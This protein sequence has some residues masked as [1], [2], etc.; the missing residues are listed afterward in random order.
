MNQE[1]IDNETEDD[2]TSER[3]ISFEIPIITT[4]SPSS[5]HDSDEISSPVFVNIL[6]RSATIVQS[7][8]ETD[9]SFSTIV[10]NNTQSS[11]AFRS[12]SPGNLNSSNT[13][14]GVMSHKISFR[15]LWPENWIDDFKLFT[16]NVRR[17][18]QSLTSASKGR[19]PKRAINILPSRLQKCK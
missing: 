17:W 12:L 13:S 18:S 16:Q 3:N 4:S 2:A 9:T 7:D 5:V 10:N 1:S 15:S 11:H 8:E 6:K 14:R 19:R